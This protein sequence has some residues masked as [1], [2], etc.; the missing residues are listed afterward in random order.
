MKLSVYQNP[1]GSFTVLCFY[2]VTLNFPSYI[3][4]WELPWEQNQ[5]RDVNL[6]ELYHRKTK[7]I[8]K[9]KGGR[10][11]QDKRGLVKRK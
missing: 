11:D 8:K 4:Y 10:V 2:N 3:M 6:Q 7:I 1:P 5:A 9:E